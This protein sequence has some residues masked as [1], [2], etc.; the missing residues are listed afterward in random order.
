MKMSEL[1]PRTMGAATGGMVVG[2][3][4]GTGG[5]VGFAFCLISYPITE[6]LS[7]SLRPKYTRIQLDSNGIIHDSTADMIQSVVLPMFLGQLAAW[8]ALVAFGVSLSITSCIVLT[9]GTMAWNILMD[10]YESC[11]R[12]SLGYGPNAY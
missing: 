3:L 7:Y 12:R 5:D 11:T 10:E 2:H 8:A 4:W 6:L 9:A 1:I